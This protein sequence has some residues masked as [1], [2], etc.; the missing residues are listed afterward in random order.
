MRRL[1]QTPRSLRASACGVLIALLSITVVL[2]G[3]PSNDDC[4][5]AIVITNHSATAGE[6]IG[7]SA[8][9]TAS[10]GASDENPDLWYQF[11]APPPGGVLVLDTCGSRDLGGPGAGAD[12]VLS[13]Y[14]AC[15]ATLETEVACNDD[16]GEVGCNTLDSRIVVAVNACQPYWIRV[17]HFGT[18]P[19]NRGNGRFVLH[20]NLQY[21]V[22]GDTNCDGLVN[23]FDISCFVLA[24]STN[25]S[26]WARSCD[27][28]QQCD[29][30]CANDINGDGLVNNFDI[31][32]FVQ[33]L[34][35]GVCP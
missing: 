33:L 11:T 34:A 10:C 18:D 7:A 25:E 27:N 30:L 15:P 21:C 6:L 26:E 19:T 28:V 12:T 4:T 5:G 20:A 9:G 22:R 8:N 2:G 13:I 3:T 14:S 29:Y 35:E 16:G 23:N 24:L 17:S 31:D 32:A 1:A